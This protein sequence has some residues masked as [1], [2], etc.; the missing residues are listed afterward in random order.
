MTAARVVEVAVDDDDVWAIGVA[1]CGP[2]TWHALYAEHLGGK[3][4]DA[5]RFETGIVARC[6]QWVQD[7]EDYAT[8][9]FPDPGH[10]AAVWPDTLPLDGWRELA[11]TAVRLSSPEGFEWAQLRLRK[12]PLLALEVY[13]SQLYQVP[14]SVFR[15]WPED[16]RAYALALVHEQRDRCPGCG[17]PTRAM[18]DYQAAHLDVTTCVHCEELE[19]QQRDADPGQHLS[20]QLTPG[21]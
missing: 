12:S 19:Q 1:G 10:I 15:S 14:L 20:I 3:D 11:D 18:L 13:A 7:G 8:R 21:V 16:D 9:S 5:D 6:V 4:P 17:V 2:D